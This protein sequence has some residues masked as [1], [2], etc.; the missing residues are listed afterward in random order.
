MDL[1]LQHQYGVDYCSYYIDLVLKNKTPAH[2]V[3]LYTDK[4]FTKVSYV[5]QMFLSV[6]SYISIYIPWD[7]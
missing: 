7:S 4:R 2:G 5:W 3:I 1:T 6:F